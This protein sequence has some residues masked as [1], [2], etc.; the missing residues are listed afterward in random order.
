[1]DENGRM[2][3][4]L[5]LLFLLL[6]SLCYA[7]GPVLLSRMT[8]AMIGGG[9]ATSV[10]CTTSNDSKWAYPVTQPGTSL[11]DPSVSTWHAFKITLSATTTVTAYK[12]RVC[13]NNSDTGSVVAS[14]Y[15]HSEVTNKPTTEVS[16]S[17][18]TV[19]ASSI[20]ACNTTGVIDFNLSTPLAG[21]V[22]KTYWIVIQDASAATH[23]AF[24][25][26]SSTDRICYGTNGTDWTCA[27][28]YEYD[29]ELWGCQ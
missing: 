20:Q 12:I 22:A 5:L 2:M 25:R 3:K 23:K 28:N 29:M 13:D 26:S 27:A 24:Y 19:A 15:D 9:G 11:T 7:D 8:P 10:S 17:S 16:G 1:M 14:L 6:P 21:V 4:R 18:A